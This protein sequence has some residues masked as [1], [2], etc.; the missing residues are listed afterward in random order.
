[1]SYQTI[2]VCFKAKYTPELDKLY[3][4]KTKDL[5]K[6]GQII[7]VIDSEGKPK[8]VRVIKIDKEYDKATEERFGTLAEA[9]AEKPNDDS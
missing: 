7:W 6:E 4:Y 1:M 3:T 8:R 9:F 5:V 2:K